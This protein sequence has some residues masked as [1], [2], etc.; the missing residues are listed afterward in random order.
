[1]ARSHVWPALHR[2]GGGGVPFGSVLRLKAGFVPPASW[3]A[4]A[5][6]V[7]DIGSDLYVQGEPSAQWQDATITNLKT[8]RASDFEFVDK[9]AITGDSRFNGDSFQASW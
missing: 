5:K 6:A 8:L 1:M 2:A 3:S 7:A 4:Q 9:R